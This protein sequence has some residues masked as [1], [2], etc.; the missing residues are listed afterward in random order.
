MICSASE[1][2]RNWTGRDVDRDLEVRRPAARLL[3]RLLHHVK[4]E[5]P[6]E[7]GCFGDLDERVG[8]EEAAGRR[9]PAGERLEADQIAASKVDQRLE[10][11][12]ELAALDAEADILLE[13][14]PLGQLA[15]ELLVEPG[16]AV[17]AGALGGIER[18]VALAQDIFLV[19]R[20]A[21][22]A[23]PIE[24]ETWTC[25]PPRNTGPRVAR[26]SPAATFSAAASPALVRSIANS[27]P[28]NL[29]Q[30]A[31]VGRARLARR[32]RSIAIGRPRGGRGDR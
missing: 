29:A 16:E 30:Q 27:S 6:D 24:A 5:R 9:A 20:C 25:A 18:D 12:D 1:A 11:G 21:R 28:P 8:L 19:L 17:A 26:G 13:L 3:Q 31:P 15:L 4:R 32:R 7:A 10:E 14:Q 22:S 23:R 2:S